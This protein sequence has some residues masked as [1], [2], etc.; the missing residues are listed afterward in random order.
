[1]T[2]GK[3]AVDDLEVAKTRI[4]DIINTLEDTTGENTLFL[5][6]LLDLIN[7]EIELSGKKADWAPLSCTTHWE[8]NLAG[9]IRLKEDA[10]EYI[11]RAGNMGTTYQDGTKE[12]QFLD[13]DLKYMR[14]KVTFDPEV[15]GPM[16]N[17]LE[18]TVDEH[19]DFLM[20][21]RR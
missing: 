16:I 15:I 11:M 8:M 7:D 1:M 14:I 9:D 21:G 10:P 12:W 13:D 6:A 18:T 20:R 5:G 3:I 4:V 19:L 17:V 2:A